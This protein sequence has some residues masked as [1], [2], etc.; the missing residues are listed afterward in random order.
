[1]DK[2]KKTKEKEKVMVKDLG[3]RKKKRKSKYIYCRICKG[4][5]CKARLSFSTRMAKT[6]KHYKRKHYSTFRAGIR[7]GVKKRSKGQMTIVGIM[8]IVMTMAVFAMTFELQTSFVNM[9]LNQTND[10]TTRL[11]VS[12]LIPFEGLGILMGIVYYASAAR[13]D[14]RGRFG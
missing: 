14:I 12:A 4:R 8:A 10:T 9:I 13:E 5:I 6:R 1:M 11:I 7:K 3:R 2:D